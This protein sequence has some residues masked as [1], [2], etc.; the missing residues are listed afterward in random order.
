MKNGNAYEVEIVSSFNETEKTECNEMKNQKRILV[1]LAV[2]VFLLALPLLAADDKTST[3]ST[4]ATTYTASTLKTDRTR[5]EILADLGKPVQKPGPIPAIP[6][7]K[8]PPYVP[9]PNN[10]APDRN[11]MCP[12]GYYCK[13]EHGGYLPTCYLGTGETNC[14]FVCRF[15]RDEPNLGGPVPGEEDKYCD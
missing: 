14:G 9:P 13:C 10:V 6:A 3:K 2:S 12:A 1:L 11:D 4:T 8:L 7:V 5:A 15:C